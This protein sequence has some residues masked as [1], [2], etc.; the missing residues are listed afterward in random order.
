MLE[1]MPPD[2]RAFARV[3]CNVPLRPGALAHVNVEDI[4]LAT[5]EAVIRKD[6]AGAG[7][8][9]VVPKVVLELARAHSK[10]K[11][12]RTPLFTRWDGMPW[13]KDSWKDGFKKA[14]AAAGL[15]ANTS[16][17]SLRH[18]AITD[19]ATGG[20]DLMNLAHVAGTSLLMIQKH[21][22]HLRAD[23]AVAHMDRIA[24]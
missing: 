19:L 7:R 1:Q 14:A 12:P 3:L 22:G 4:N 8:R 15:P 21:Y 11:L 20:M 9:F 5:G 18:S 6:K 10:N 23:Q 24:I 17:Y 13:N 16:M 2:L